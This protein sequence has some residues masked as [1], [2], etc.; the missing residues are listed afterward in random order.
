MDTLL[1]H[2]M[3][4]YFL[5]IALLGSARFVERRCSALVPTWGVHRQIGPMIYVVPLNVYVH[6]WG[7]AC[8]CGDF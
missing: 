1:G 2:D 3:S 7:K 4:I 6:L 8:T 5:V